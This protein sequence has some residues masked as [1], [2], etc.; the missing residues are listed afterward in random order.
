MTE[1]LTV[2]RVQMN[3]MTSYGELEQNTLH[4][5]T[6]NTIIFTG[7]F[8]NVFL[9]D[10]CSTDCEPQCSNGVCMSSRPE[11]QVGYKNMNSPNIFLID[12]AKTLLMRISG[13][14]YNSSFTFCYTI[15]RKN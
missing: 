2:I 3:C 9:V 1:L 4:I 14:L 5:S 10:R 11:S 7:Q 8:T 12:L 6:L 15:I 13:K